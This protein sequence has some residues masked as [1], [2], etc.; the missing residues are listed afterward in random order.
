MFCKKGV[1]RCFA[2]FTGKHQCQGLSFSK[3]AGL[4]QVFSCKFWKISKNIFS[5]RTPPVAASEDIRMFFMVKYKTTEIILLTIFHWFTIILHTYFHSEQLSAHSFFVMISLLI[6]I[7]K[8]KL[9]TNNF[10]SQ[11]FNLKIIQYCLHK[12]S[13]VDKFFEYFA[14]ICSLFSH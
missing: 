12:L 10:C 14:Q 6:Y 9:E 7:F 1:L 11:S 3:V 13:T 5:Y 2:K 8:T 4:A